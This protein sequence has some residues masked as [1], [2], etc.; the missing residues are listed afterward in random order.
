MSKSVTATGAN[1]PFAR[2]DNGSGPVQLNNST[3]RNGIRAVKLRD[4]NDLVIDLGSIYV[5]PAPDVYPIVLATYEVIWSQGYDPDTAAAVKSFLS[6]AT[7][8]GQTH[9]AD[10]GYTPLPDSLKSRL[11]YAINAIG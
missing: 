3:V 4:G 1:L 5:T 2:I 9:L 7:N 8:E 10:I 6:V 11:R